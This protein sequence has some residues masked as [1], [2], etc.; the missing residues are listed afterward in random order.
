M[1]IRPAVG[2]ATAAKLKQLH[3]KVDVMP[4]DDFTAAAVAGA[5]A[6][7]ESLENLK[8]LLLRAEVAN[9]DL[10]RKLEELGA[11]VDNIACYK[12]VPETEDRNGAV[13]RL[14]EEGIRLTSPMQTVMTVSP[15]VVASVPQG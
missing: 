12:T 1:P 6:K 7:Y 13:A 2:P 3:L 15:Q 5:L 11:I 4:P 8:I 9:P 10:P 14:R